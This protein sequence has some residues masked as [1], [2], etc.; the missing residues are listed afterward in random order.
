MNSHRPALREELDSLKRQRILA[1]ARR[2]FFELGYRNTTMEAVAQAVGMGK[3]F[4]YRHFASKVDLLVELYDQ[5]IALSEAALNN[6]L[7]EQRRP[8]QTIRA[9]VRRY[10]DVVVSEREIVAIFFRELI[11]VPHEK[12]LQINDHKR[13]FDNRLTAVI[14][15]GIETEEFRVQSARVAAFAIVGMVNWCYQWYRPGA[16]FGPAELGEMFSEFALRILDG[17]DS[18]QLN[19]G[20]P[21]E[22]RL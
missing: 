13:A 7:A 6:A 21:L 18:T 14:Q 16:A 22:E 15:E 8:R 10:L 17:D 3:P 2:L 20:N 12:L 19:P 5:A 9:F 11:N 1:E 4:V